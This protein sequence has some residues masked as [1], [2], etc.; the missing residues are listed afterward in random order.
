MHDNKNKLIEYFQKFPG[1][2]PK[3]AQRFV[4]FLMKQNKSYIDNLTKNI[5]SLK[6]NSFECRECHAY[7]SIDKQEKNNICNICGSED[8]DKSQIIL[9]EKE[10]DVDAIEKTGEYTGTYFV[11]GGKLPFLS[12][13][14]TENIKIKELVDKI[15]RHI[16]NKNLTEI[17]FA[18]PAT[19]EGDYEMEYIRKTISQIVGIKDVQ[20]SSLARGVSTGLEMEYVDHDTFKNAFSGRK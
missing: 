12:A 10:L 5:D 1:I 6:Q 18:L 7:Y 13:N 2:G 19:D 3:Q 9:V 16:D 8:R 17:I 14:P 4:Y 20:I 15:R 11:M